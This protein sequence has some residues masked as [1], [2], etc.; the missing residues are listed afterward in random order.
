MGKTN[1]PEVTIKRKI[2]ESDQYIV[3]DENF[4]DV[5]YENEQEYQKEKQEIYMNETAM[6][7][8]Q[9]IL[10]YTNDGFHPLCEYLDYANVENYV[11]WIL[12]K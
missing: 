4:E 6:I 9:K 7:I 10:E 8:R 12:T 11:N 2:K 3:L 5:D 1:R